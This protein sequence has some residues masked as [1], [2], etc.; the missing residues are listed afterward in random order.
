MRSAVRTRQVAEV[1]NGVRYAEPKTNNLST[2]VWEDAV[3]ASA[4][5]RMRSAVRTRQVAEVALLSRERLGLTL[6]EAVTVTGDDL[7][8]HDF[9][10]A[11]GEISNGRLGDVGLKVV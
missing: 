8:A 11:R 3:S 1:A 2:L 7:A 9:G 5:A 4:S 10:P 6:S